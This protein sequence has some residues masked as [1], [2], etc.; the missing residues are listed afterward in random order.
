MTQ[1]FELTKEINSNQLAKELEDVGLDRG[2][3]ER[4]SDEKSIIV[5]IDDDKKV[6]DILD[7]HTPDNE[8]EATL[9]PTLPTLEEIKQEKI[10]EIDNLKDIIDIKE[11]LKKE[12]GLV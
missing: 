9:K 7:S 5:F 4:H 6:K 2:F 1:E 3:I 11:Y 10:D 8:L 12:R